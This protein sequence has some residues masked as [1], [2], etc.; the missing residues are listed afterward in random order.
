MFSFLLGKYLEVEW[1]SH[2][3][4]IYLYEELP[5]LGLNEHSVSNVWSPTCYVSSPMVGIA[6]LLNVSYSSGKEM[7]THSSALAWRI[8]WTEKPGGLHSTGSQRVRH[9]WA[10]LLSLTFISVGVLVSYYSYN[11][12]SL[13]INDVEHLFMYLLFICQVS[14][15]ISCPFKERWIPF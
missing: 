5:D 11:L 2:R 13:M 8:P 15:W 3:A 7:A 1:L 10:T 4:G 12:I 6:I 14:V 9:G